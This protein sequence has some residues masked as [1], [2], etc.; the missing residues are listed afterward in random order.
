MSQTR[1]THQLMKFSLNVREIHGNHSIQRNVHNVWCNVWCRNWGQFKDLVCHLQ[2]HGWEVRRPLVT[3]HKA[4]QCFHR[5]LSV[6]LFTIGLMATQSLIILVTAP[7]VCILLECFL[8][9]YE[10]ESLWLPPT[11][12]AC[13]GYVITGVCLST[14]GCVVDTDTSPGRYI[15]LGR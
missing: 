2:L 4:R 6:I 15:P 7:S 9:P 13:E 5:R 12:E 8:V 11:N 14:G 1:I 10:V 3:D